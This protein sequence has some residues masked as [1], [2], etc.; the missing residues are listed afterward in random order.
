MATLSLGQERV[1]RLRENHSAALIL[2][3]VPLKH[4]SVYIMHGPRFQKDY[5]HEVPKVAGK[6]GEEMDERISVTFRQHKVD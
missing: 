6:K 3:D 4:G 2:K 1:L 5:T